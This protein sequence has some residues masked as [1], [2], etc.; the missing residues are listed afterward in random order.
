MSPRDP[1]DSLH[2]SWLAKQFREAID[3][4]VPEKQQEFIYHSFAK[5]SK[6]NP[7]DLVHQMRVALIA[8]P[9]HKH[10]GLDEIEGFIE[11]ALHD[12]GRIYTPGIAG[13]KTEQWDEEKRAKGLLHPENGAMYLRA[14]GFRDCAEVILGH[15]QFQPDYY[16]KEHTF[17]SPLLR[18]RSEIL[19]AADQLDAMT[20]RLNG[21]PHASYDEKESILGIYKTK[22]RKEFPDHFQFVKELLEKGILAPPA[23]HSLRSR[24]IA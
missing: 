10:F 3:A 11:A 24:Y 7:C 14:A 5:V 1:N 18:L 21:G 13:L 19:A 4:I 16:P 20:S 15:H 9:I 8:H 6:T 22:E 17:S 12:V 2:P 23:T